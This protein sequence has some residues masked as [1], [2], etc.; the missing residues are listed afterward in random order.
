[1]IW[2]NSSLQIDFSV[3]TSDVGQYS[4][5]LDFLEFMWVLGSLWG[6]GED[7]GSLDPNG[8][9]HLETNAL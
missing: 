7:F 5:A 9:V 6:K 8:G 2:Y 1:M 3:T 4:R